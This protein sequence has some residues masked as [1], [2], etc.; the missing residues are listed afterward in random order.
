MVQCGKH[1]SSELGLYTQVDLCSNLHSDVII[2][3]LELLPDL[4]ELIYQVVIRHKK[5]NV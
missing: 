5:G 3:D 4:S 1:A 2:C